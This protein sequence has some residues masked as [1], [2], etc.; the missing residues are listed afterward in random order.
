MIYEPG[1]DSFLLASVFFD[2]IPKG[3]QVLDVGCGSGYLMEKIKELGSEV[4]GVDINPEAVE[5]CRKKNLVVVISD[6]FEHVA[7]VFDVIIF[8]PP[9]LP[10]DEAEDIESKMITTG[11]KEGFELLELFLADAKAH[12]TDEG[13]ILLVVSSLTGDVEYL[14]KKYGYDFKLLKSE[15]HFFEK[16]LVYELKFI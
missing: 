12:L 2:Y 6:L 13:S 7:G 11:G 14:F 16:L 3:S 4:I 9:Y 15:S 8:N 1:E 5:Y 10:L